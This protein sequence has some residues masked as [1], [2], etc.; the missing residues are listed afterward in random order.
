MGLDMTPGLPY[1]TMTKNLSPTPTSQQLFMTLTMR[2]FC[3]TSSTKLVSSDYS[4]EM[5]RMTMKFK[6]NEV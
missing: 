6:T 2:E 3:G 4:N 1:T 5:S